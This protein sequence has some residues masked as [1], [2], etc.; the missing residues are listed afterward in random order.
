MKCSAHHQDAV[1]VCAY[2]G[3]AL[4]SACEPISSSPRMACSAA[5]ADAL[6]ANARAVELTLG[7][8][9]Q[10]AKATA[11]GSY[12]LGV[13]LI[14]FAIYGHHV[15]PKIPVVHPLAAALGAALLLWGFWFHRVSREK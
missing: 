10:S 12:L 15:E 7:K 5:C 9:V 4:C 8:S 14:A 11:Y 2:C 3:R 13:L 1:A 6:A